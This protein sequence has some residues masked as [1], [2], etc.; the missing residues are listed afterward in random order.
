MNVE[1]VSDQKTVKV[2]IRLVVASNICSHSSYTY[3]PAVT[4]T[5]TQHSFHIRTGIAQEHRDTSTGM[6]WGNNRAIGGDPLRLLS[7]RRRSKHN[8]LYR[9]LEW[10]YGTT[11]LFVPPHPSSNLQ[12]MMYEIYLEALSTQALHNLVSV[13]HTTSFFL[14]VSDT[15]RHSRVSTRPAERKEH[16][17]SCWCETNGPGRTFRAL[18]CVPQVLHADELVISV[19]AVVLGLGVVVVQVFP[20][21]LKQENDV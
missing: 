18:P 6:G 11:W 10:S 13:Q 4:P 15:G 12:T 20:Q 8:T 1:Q 21:E 19:E 16:L 7:R 3:G 2:T 14:F 17:C 5:A 9:H